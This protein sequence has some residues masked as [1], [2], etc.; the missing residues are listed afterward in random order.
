MAASWSAAAQSSF[1]SADSTVVSSSSSSSAWSS[2]A[3][4][5][6]ASA[7]SWSSL[8]LLD[9]LPSRSLR[10][11]LGCGLLDC[12]GQ[13]QT[14]RVTLLTASG[15]ELRSGFYFEAWTEPSAGHS[16]N[17]RIHHV[18]RGSSAV[19]LGCEQL[20]LDWFGDE[21]ELVLHLVEYSGAKQSRD[22]PVAELRVPREAVKRYAVEA[23]GHG[24]VVRFGPRTFQMCRLGRQEALQRKRRFQD[25]PLPS[26]LVAKMFEKIGEEQG[27]HIPSSA[28]LERLSAENFALRK[29]NSELWTKFGL[30]GGAPIASAASAAAAATAAAARPVAVAVRFELVQAGGNIDI[31][32]ELPYRKASFQGDASAW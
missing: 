15:V 10:Q 7:S 24:D 28:E 17:S 13:P 14:L 32:F 19:D 1:A 25:M 27:L 30:P 3:V 12:Q 23:S 18:R 22:L 21:K 29:Q 26:F 9:L 6:S 5:T 31:E 4:Q 16:K 2:S 20:D 11:A 8:S